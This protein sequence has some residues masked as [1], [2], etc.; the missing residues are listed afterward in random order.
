MSVE[1]KTKVVGGICQMRCPYEYKTGYSDVRIGSTWC[2]Q[3]PQFI[4]K[5]STRKDDF[6]RDYEVTVT[7]KG[8]TD[9]RSNV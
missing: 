7:C 6:D 8:E 1:L 3:C 2:K 5:A 9:M 4:G